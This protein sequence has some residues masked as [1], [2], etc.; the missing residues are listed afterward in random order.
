MDLPKTVCTRSENSDEVTS[1]EYHNQ[2]GVENDKGDSVYNDTSG[3]SSQAYSEHVNEAFSS[4]QVK[5]EI[6]IEYGTNEIDEEVPMD[7]EVTN[8]DAVESSLSSVSE[9]S[10][11]KSGETIDK[12]IGNR[13]D[14]EVDPLKTR[15]IKIEAKS[16]IRRPE[17]E[18]EEGEI[19]R[20]GLD[21]NT[22]VGN[23][24]A[25]EPRSS[26]ESS[27]SPPKDAVDSV[28]QDN[29]PSDPM[30]QDPYADDEEKL[31]QQ[32]MEDS[33]TQ[34][35]AAVTTTAKSTEDSVLP[36]GLDGYGSP[37][38]IFEDNIVR[39]SRW[40]DEGRCFR[41]IVDKECPA[42][43]LQDETSNC[44]SM[45][46]ISD[47]DEDFSESFNG[48]ES[49]LEAG[50]IPRRRLRE[51]IDVECPEQ[52]LQ[53]T[54]DYSC[55]GSQ[56]PSVLKQ[57][58]IDALRRFDSHSHDN[59]TESISSTE[60]EPL[61][62][63]ESVRSGQ[64][65]PTLVT[66]KAVD[67]EGS[68]NNNE[69]VGE[70]FNEFPNPA[71]EKKGFPHAHSV[72]V[73]VSKIQSS[74][75]LGEV[76]PAPSDIT[77]QSCSG[78]TSYPIITLTNK[79]VEGDTASSSSVDG[80]V[81]SMMKNRDGARD[82]TFQI[83]NTK[84][85]LVKKP[86]D[87]TDLSAGDDE[88][89]IASIGEEFVL[90]LHHSSDFDSSETEPISDEEL[91]DDD[92][93]KMGTR[94]IGSSEIA[95]LSK[96]M[97]SSG[98]FKRNKRKRDDGEDAF[99]Q[100][101]KT[102]IVEVSDAE[103]LIAALES[104]VKVDVAASSH[105]PG[106][107]NAISPT[108]ATRSIQ[109]AKF[110]INKVCSEELSTNTSSC[111]RTESETISANTK[112][113]K[114]T[115]V[116][117]TKQDVEEGLTLTS[118]EIKECGR[119]ERE[120][121]YA[122]PCESPKSDVETVE[123]STQCVQT[124]DDDNGDDEPVEGNSRAESPSVEDSTT[125]Q[126]ILVSNVRSLG[127]YTSPVSPVAAP[128]TMPA[129]DSET[130]NE[131][132]EISSEPVV[133][134]T[135]HG[136]PAIATII[137]KIQDTAVGYE[138]SQHHAS[139]PEKGASPIG[140]THPV[141]MISPEPATVAYVA[142]P[143]TVTVPSQAR[144]IYANPLVTTGAP[145]VLLAQ[146]VN[147]SQS[148]ATTSSYGTAA[149]AS[150]QPADMVVSNYRIV[151]APEV[152]T[153]SGVSAYSNA[154]PSFRFIYEN[155]EPV[156]TTES[157]EPMDNKMRI[158]YACAAATADPPGNCGPQKLKLLYAEALG[159]GTP[160][161]SGQVQLVYTSTA[162]NQNIVHAPNQNVR[163][164][165]PTFLTADTSANSKNIEM[166]FAQQPEVEPSAG[167]VPVEVLYNG[168]G[169]VMAQ[170]VGQPQDLSWIRRDLNHSFIP[171]SPSSAVPQQSSSSTAGNHCAS[172]TTTSYSSTN[173][174]LST[175]LASTREIVNHHNYASSPYINA[176]KRSRYA[177]PYEQQQQAQGESDGLRTLA[178]AAATRMFTIQV[179]PRRFQYC[180]Y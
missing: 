110:I 82:S 135:E 151:Y 86:M 76:A 88:L 121:F 18:L 66:A 112:D 167:P 104:P 48:P 113:I 52:I 150:A 89:K 87:N 117:E 55:G 164:Y 172:T 3:Q 75:V 155:G 170:T 27:K 59:D 137:E 149:T 102:K 2:M 85:D 26:S 21:N 37:E 159:V 133:I 92:Q 50:E 38:A 68:D 165:S 41:G 34:N 114:V 83:E 116:E 138:L 44:G 94:K 166:L 91:E 160:D 141:E 136:I 5:S 71:L 97:S 177:M 17:S 125:E 127:G 61:P 35:T 156:L 142:I 105:I 6:D 58:A 72:D 49:P 22:V 175:N 53:P 67:D 4:Y 129:Y 39:S 12:D 23:E 143:E 111:E 144:L 176:D 80:P 148:T 74:A 77:E 7:E 157:T 158:V 99:S 79:Q 69:A 29:Y 20:D 124:E 146:P 180:W 139:I 147:L 14:I 130:A 13:S 15:S 154:Q 96:G 134:K 162:P 126:Q 118:D 152:A 36:D 93:A 28:A 128:L 90:S 43:I 8:A 81:Q 106:P 64:L 63:D 47:D 109:E 24:E 119:E 73:G 78:Q 179:G 11:K 54:N 145:A 45:D 131:S 40:K 173:A 115:A 132:M 19:E 103:K 84:T 31:Q 65:Q 163:I 33:K 95:S 57:N 25:T 46:P 30:F 169:T 98:D 1:S 10:G 42:S 168:N 122:V 100:H 32:Q 171:T 60:L 101:V 140:N 108:A 120:L 51:S 70:A 16:Q 9:T 107:K 153:T 161:E 178:R 174:R 62:E 56:E 123:K